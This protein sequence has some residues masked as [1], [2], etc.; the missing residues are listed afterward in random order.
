MAPR[1][2]KRVGPP[3]PG[4]KGGGP[5]RW[6]TTSELARV[7]RW[8]E[9]KVPGKVQA[10]RLGRTYFS[11]KSGV[12][13]HNLAGYDKYVGKDHE[14]REYIARRLVQGATQTQVAKERGHKAHTTVGRI[15]REM[16]RNGI[17]KRINWEKYGPGPRWGER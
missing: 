3:A 8:Q 4:Y 1:K 13:R 5:G 16:L 6:W 15:T 2:H 7:A 9:Q 10:A 17:L 12:R 11:W 14:L